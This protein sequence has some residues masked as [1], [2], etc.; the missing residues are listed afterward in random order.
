MISRILKN[1]KTTAIGL[2]IILSALALVYLEK[3]TLS[4]AGA[5]ISVGLVLL[6]SKDPQ[7]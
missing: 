3:T 5:F 2:G 4:D 7:K 6:F 1:W